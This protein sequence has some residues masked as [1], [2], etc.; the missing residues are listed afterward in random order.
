[1]TPSRP[2]VWPV[3]TVLVATVLLQ[4]IGGLVLVVGLMLFHRGAP[5]Q[6]MQTP[7]NGCASHLL[8]FATTFDA[9]AAKAGLP[10]PPSGSGGT[11]KF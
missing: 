8:P 1:M 11:L 3:F 5:S 7:P 4:V 2:R 9:T 6:L 10:I